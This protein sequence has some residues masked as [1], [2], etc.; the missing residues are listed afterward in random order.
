MG[1]AAVDALNA[2]Q[3]GFC[4]TVETVGTEIS[5]PFHKNSPRRAG[6]KQISRRLSHFQYDTESI[7]TLRARIAMPARKKLAER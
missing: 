2:D 3:S 7:V 4:V 6:Q 5:T 1:P